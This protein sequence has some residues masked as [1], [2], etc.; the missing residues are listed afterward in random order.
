MYVEVIMKHLQMLNGSRSKVIDGR[1]QKTLRMH[2]RHT[3]LSD[4]LQLP[5]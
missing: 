3:N 2:E 4:S 1:W 5:L